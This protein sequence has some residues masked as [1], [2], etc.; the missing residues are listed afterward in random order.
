MPE[1]VPLT[2]SEIRQKAKEIQD[3]HNTQTA[4]NPYYP[5]LLAV[6]EQVLQVARS[7]GSDIFFYTCPIANELYPEWNVKDLHT[8]IRDLF[9]GAEIYYRPYDANWGFEQREGF[10][11]SWCTYEYD[12][13]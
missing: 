13:D 1:L 8:E 11:I 2:P 6:Y 3:D 7:G 10:K 5:I 4:K 9:P 12:S